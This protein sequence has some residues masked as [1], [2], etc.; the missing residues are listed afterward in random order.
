MPLSL[1]EPVLD[2]LEW[3]LECAAPVPPR[4][5][6]GLGGCDG[7]DHPHCGHSQQSLGRTIRDYHGAQSCV[8][9]CPFR[10]HKVAVNTFTSTFAILLANTSSN[11]P[12]TTLFHTNG[13]LFNDLDLINSE[14]PRFRNNK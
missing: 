4:F 14:Y 10:G 2:N 11:T 6:P 3:E 13:S 12:L 1:L 5:E 7:C 8:R 9:Q